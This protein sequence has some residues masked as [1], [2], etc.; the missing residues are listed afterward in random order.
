[1]LGSTTPATATPAPRTIKPQQAKGQPK[2]SVPIPGESPGG[3]TQAATEYSSI[4]S[5]ASDAERPQRKLKGSAQL[6]TGNTS[7]STSGKSS[8][9]SAQP[10]T[11]NSS[12]SSSASDSEPPQKKPKTGV[13]SLMNRAEMQSKQPSHTSSDP[14]HQADGSDNGPEEAGGR[15]KTKVENPARGETTPTWVQAGAAPHDIEPDKGDGGFRMRE[16]ISG[17]KNHS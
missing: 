6:A 2:S 3:S 12:V 15:K 4:S 8:S 1:M 5:S 10:A 14:N 7:T 9:A 13:T 11:E 16:G 17:G